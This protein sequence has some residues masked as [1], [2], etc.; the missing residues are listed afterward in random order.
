ML[1][2]SITAHFA[3]IGAAEGGDNIYTGT[4]SLTKIAQSVTVTPEPASL[5]LISTGF[6]RVL[7]A[8]RRRRSRRH[9]STQM[10]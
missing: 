7:T 10:P 4:H 5:L 6:A 2:I 3:Y 1:P 9:Q 8:V